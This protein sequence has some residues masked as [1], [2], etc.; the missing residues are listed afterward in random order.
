MVEPLFSSTPTSAEVWL[1]L[2]EASPTHP[3]VDVYVHMCSKWM[4]TYMV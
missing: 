3:S 1:V 4:V 2:C